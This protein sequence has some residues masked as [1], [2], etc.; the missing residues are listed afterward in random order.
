MSTISCSVVNSAMACHFLFDGRS[1]LSRRMEPG[2]V[3]NEVL[4]TRRPPVNLANTANLA[5][6]GDVCTR[7]DFKSQGR[8]RSGRDRRMAA[9]HQ[10]LQGQGSCC[11]LPVL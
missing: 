10:R 8:L 6:V 1:T 2:S 11:R 7:N 9:A 5:G 3:A 4:P